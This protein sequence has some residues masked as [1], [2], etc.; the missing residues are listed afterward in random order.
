MMSWFSLEFMLNRILKL[1]EDEA[2]LLN[3][4]AYY[5]EINEIESTKC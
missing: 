3:F 4:K 5:I 1:M 2:N